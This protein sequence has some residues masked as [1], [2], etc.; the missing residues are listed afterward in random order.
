[1][2]T[3]Q[4]YIDPQLKKSFLRTARERGQSGSSVMR[5]FIQAYTK[6]PQI[7]DDEYFFDA[8]FDTPA[9]HLAAKR[10]ALVA[11]KCLS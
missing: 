8:S 7:F 1:M 2:T 6:N 3:Y 5:A 11:K 10:L 9:V 4:T